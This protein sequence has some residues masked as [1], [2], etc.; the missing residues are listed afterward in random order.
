MWESVMAGIAIAAVNGAAAMA[1]IQW[2]W[3]RDPNF[4]VKVFLGGIVLRL[5]LVGVA[6]ALV[7]KFTQLAR[8]PFVAAL[9]VTFIGFQ[10]AE[11]ILVARRR[12]GEVRAAS[13]TPRESSD[14]AAE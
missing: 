6:V 5:L 12:A 14:E 13:E 8:A 7:L 1:T 4:F 2:S 3:H 10:V 9:I 11:V